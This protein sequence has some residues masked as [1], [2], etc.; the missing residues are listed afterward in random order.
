MTIKNILITIVVLLAPMYLSFAEDDKKPPVKAEPKMSSPKGAKVYIIYPKDGKTVN[1][2]FPVK[3]GVK[4]MGVAPAGIKFPNTGHHHLIIDGAKFD[5]KLPLPMSDTIKHFGAGQTETLLELKPGKHTL[6][7]VFADH[8]HRIHE[9]AV[10][11]DEI[12]ITVKE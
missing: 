1:K 3:F 2:K 6:K 12:T 8:L 9:P 7:L 11:S 10:I 4:K 5:M